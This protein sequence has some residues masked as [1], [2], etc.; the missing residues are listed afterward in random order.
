MKKKIAALAGAGVLLLSMAGPAF[1]IFDWGGSSSELN[2]YNGAS[3]TN[4][5][6]T[7]AYTG[8]NGIGGMFVK[9]SIWTGAAGATALVAND[10]NSSVVASCDCYDTINIYNGASVYNKTYTKADT[11]DNG[12]GGMWNGGWIHTGGAGATSV[13][14]NLVNFSLVGGG[15]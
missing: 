13:V 8:D 2:I 15:M 6:Y 9:G 1:G 4:R 12:V 5:T 7:K 10:V 14:D 11:G 3:V